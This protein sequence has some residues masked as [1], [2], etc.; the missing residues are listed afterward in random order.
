VRLG[1]KDMHV[2]PCCDFSSICYQ[3]QGANAPEA[4]DTVA[5]MNEV[6]L[7]AFRIQRLQE[8]ID[9][10][11]VGNKTDFGRKLGFKDGAFVRQMLSGTRPI[12]E[13]TVRAVEALHGMKGWFSPSEAPK[14][15]QPARSSTKNIDWPLKKATLDRFYAL[16]PTQAKRADAAIDDLLR[17]YEAERGK[18]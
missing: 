4:Y 13:K 8:A 9:L 11:S 10:V 16:T 2:G 6:E 17:G 12:T 3:N 14:A 18:I 1:K 7:S 15:A 5:T